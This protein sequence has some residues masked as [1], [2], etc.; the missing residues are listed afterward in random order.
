MKTAK[1]ELAEALSHLSELLGKYGHHSKRQVVDEILGTL[2]NSSPDYKRLA[3]VEVWGGAGAVW[4][5]CLTPNWTADTTQRE[6]ERS[7]LQSLI[8]VA[9]AMERL[10]IGNDRTRSLSKTF[11]EWLSQKTI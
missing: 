9:D 6:D 4:E 7:F 11:R 10:Q 3:G 5:V 1:E 8:G 2:R